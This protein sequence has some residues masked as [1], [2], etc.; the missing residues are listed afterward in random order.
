MEKKEEFIRVIKNE[1]LPI[2]RK[3]AGFLEFLLLFP[4]NMTEK[5][6]IVP[7]LDGEETLRALREG[8]AQAHIS[9]RFGLSRPDARLGS[10]GRTSCPSVTSI[11][12][13]WRL[14]LRLLVQTIQSSS[15]DVPPSFAPVASVN[16]SGM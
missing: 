4:E 6:R 14:A 11:T 16:G 10:C 12:A 1:V 8:V 2:L 5:A 3:P 7:P 13:R 15:F 9:E